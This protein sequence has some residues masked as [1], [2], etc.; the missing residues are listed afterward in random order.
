MRVASESIASSVMEDAATGAASFGFSDLPRCSHDACAPPAIT[1]RT[2]AILKGRTRTVQR[3]KWIAA[4]LRVVAIVVGIGRLF[5]DLLERLL[6][7]RRG[8]RCGAAGRG[9]R[10]SRRRCR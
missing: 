9:D 10:S 6:N 4:S 5:Q 7:V 3:L 8:G 1:R 2:L